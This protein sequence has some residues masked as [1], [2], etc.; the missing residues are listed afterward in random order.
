MRPIGIAGIASA[1]LLSGCAAPP[2]PALVAEA[3]APVIC[4]GKADCAAV[5]SRAVAW[6]TMNSP[7]NITVQTDQII[8]TYPPP[9]GD[10]DQPQIKAYILREA[11]GD[12]RV[13]IGISPCRL[14]CI[15]SRLQIAASFHAFVLQ[16][17]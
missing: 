2:S 17:Q 15:P 11:N 4:H 7:L 13:K 10:D 3:H 8:Q 6:V 5:W 1:L 12:G 14:W 9:P 16:G